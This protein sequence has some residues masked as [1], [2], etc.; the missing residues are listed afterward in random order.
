MLSQLKAAK[1][2]VGIKQCKKAIKDGTAEKVFY[3]A[4]AER[5]LTGPIIESCAQAGI[6]CTAVDT[7]GE[8]GAACGIE[9]GA[10]VAAMMK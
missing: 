4:D 9:V 6:E 10:A 7:M 5:R 8:L 3:A 2:V 1:K